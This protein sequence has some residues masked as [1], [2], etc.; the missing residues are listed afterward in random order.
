MVLQL[1][2]DEIP[3]LKAQAEDLMKS[4]FTNQYQL[5]AKTKQLNELETQLNFTNDECTRRQEEIDRITKEKG[6]IEA[7]LTKEMAE[8]DKLVQYISRL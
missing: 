5:E 7:R 8:V 3:R 1:T 2:N 4:L 6:D